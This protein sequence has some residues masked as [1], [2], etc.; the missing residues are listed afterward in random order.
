[1]DKILKR[2]KN[3][4]IT[5]DLICFFSENHQAVH[6]LTDKGSCINMVSLQP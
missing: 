6:Q 4:S 3:E 2:E 1:M 5:Q